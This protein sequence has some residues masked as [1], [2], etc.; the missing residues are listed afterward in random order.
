VKAEPDVP[1]VTGTR[2]RYACRSIAEVDAHLTGLLSW[3]DRNLP[4]MHP[5]QRRAAEANYARD[6]DKLLNARAML[7]SLLT[8]EEDLADLSVGVI[9]EADRPTTIGDS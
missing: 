2:T 1:I 5:G 7:A 6:I 8:L 3:L 4:K 9:R